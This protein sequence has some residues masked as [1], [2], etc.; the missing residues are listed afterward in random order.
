MF[1]VPAA[2]SRPH[3]GFF[4]PYNLM[5]AMAQANLNDPHVQLQIY[6]YL[7]VLSSCD[8]LEFL[9]PLLLSYILLPLIF[10]TAAVI[11]NKLKLML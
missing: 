11:W 4:A 10:E 6:M 2:S 5:L 7:L 1:A 9:D 3:S 8:L